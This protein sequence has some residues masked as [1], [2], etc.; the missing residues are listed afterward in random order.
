MALTSVG[1]VVSN[2]YASSSSSVS[3][4]S[5]I[6]VPAGA[7]LLAIITI[8]NISTTDGN[9]STVTSFTDTA[10]N[11]WTKVGEYTNANG[12]AGSGATVAA[13]YC[14]LTNAITSG[15][16]TASFSAA[17]VGRGIV[18][19]RYTPGSTTSTFAIEGLTTLG[20]DATQNEPGS[21][22]ISGLSSTNRLFVRAV[23][24]EGFDTLT[25][26]PTSGY[27]AFSGTSNGF[28]YSG[29]SVNGEFI[30]STATSQTSNPTFATANQAPD[31]ASMFF[32]IR[33]DMTAP[34]TSATVTAL[35]GTVGALV[36]AGRAND[37]GDS[38]WGAND[39]GVVPFAGST[40][41]T[42]SNIAIIVGV[43]GAF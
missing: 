26:T 3:N 41:N 9:T 43:M 27:T 30:S 25:V 38:G 6:T 20:V 2:C 21:M 15:F 23:A 34:L 36:V 24:G 42:T 11:T 31:W 28:G 17:V 13:F 33:E 4:S 22:T 40:G 7:F 29:M 32:A 37:I 19:H 5:S 8:D 16:V 35:R 39:F 18:V 10:S 12:A 14:R 1:S